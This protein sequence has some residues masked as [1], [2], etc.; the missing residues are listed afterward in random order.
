[1]DALDEETMEYFRGSNV[2]VLKVSREDDGLGGC[3][4][5]LAVGGLW[6]SHQKSLDCDAPVPPEAQKRQVCA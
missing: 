6:T 1:M 2:A 3:C 4:G 5:A